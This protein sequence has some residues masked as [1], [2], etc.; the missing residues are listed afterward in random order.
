MALLVGSL[1]HSFLSS[2]QTEAAAATS[3]RKPSAIDQNRINKSK[4]VDAGL[5][6]PDL[7]CGVRPGVA[8]ARFQLRGVFICDL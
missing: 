1:Q 4:F 6:L 2:R 8:S 3:E 5:D 7:L